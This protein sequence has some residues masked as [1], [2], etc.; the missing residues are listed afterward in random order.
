MTD[1]YVINKED[2]EP[3]SHQMVVTFPF[4][5]Q[6]VREQWINRIDRVR[7]SSLSLVLQKDRE[8]LLPS[9][10]ELRA[11]K[12]AVCFAIQNKVIG[13]EIADNYYHK[14][15]TMRGKNDRGII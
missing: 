3:F 8:T 6:I 11:L 13:A 4:M 14:L 15:K 9:D 7:T 2:F 12:Q 1:D 5:P 10:E